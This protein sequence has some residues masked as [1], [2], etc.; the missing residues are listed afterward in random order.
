M[1][2]VQMDLT[3]MVIGQVEIIEEMI[4]DSI[5][6]MGQILINLMEKVRQMLE[7]ML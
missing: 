1:V 2:A 5:S 6:M 3:L 7:G 4:E